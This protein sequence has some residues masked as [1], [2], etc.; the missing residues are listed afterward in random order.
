VSG[1]PVVQLVEALRVGSP[2]GAVGEGTACRVTR[3]RS[4]LRHCVSGHPVVHLV[5]AL[6]VGSPGGAVG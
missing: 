1:H 3:W 5:E 2:G 4:W 6:R